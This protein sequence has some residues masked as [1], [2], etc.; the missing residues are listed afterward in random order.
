MPTNNY[1]VHL[2]VANAGSLESRQS[3]D[4]FNWLLSRVSNITFETTSG[5]K[6]FLVGELADRL[7]VKNLPSPAP[8]MGIES[9]S[10]AG[11]SADLQA[12]VARVFFGAESVVEYVFFFSGQRCLASMHVEDDN[13]IELSLTAAEATQLA[14]ELGDLRRNVVYCR[15]NYDAIASAFSQDLRGWVALGALAEEEK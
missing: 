10:V 12:V 1:I 8:D 15:E 2:G 13:F 6:C 7:T 11:D 3:H 5:G 9:F 4:L 14:D